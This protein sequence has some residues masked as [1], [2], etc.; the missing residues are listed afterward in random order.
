MCLFVMGQKML[1]SCLVQFKLGNKMKI[2]GQN[3]T[4]VVFLLYHHFYSLVLNV[5]DS[6]QLPDE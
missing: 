3:Y 5:R 6:L 1:K 2:K 4:C